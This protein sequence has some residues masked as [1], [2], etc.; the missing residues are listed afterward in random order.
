LI[1]TFSCDS[2]FNFAFNSQI[3]VYCKK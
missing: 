2:N 3:L 1:S